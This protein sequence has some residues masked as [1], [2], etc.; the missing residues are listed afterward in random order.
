MDREGER[1][2]HYCYSNLHFFKTV[3]PKLKSA[4]NSSK[5]AYL[6]RPSPSSP[7]SSGELLRSISSS[8]ELLSG[9]SLHD[10]VISFLLVV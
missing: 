2:I 4:L 5:K 3:Q 10:I 6:K 8:L 9:L 1:P 7:A